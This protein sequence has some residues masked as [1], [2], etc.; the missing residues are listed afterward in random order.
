MKKT[1]G[2]THALI[3]IVLLTLVL[4]PRPFVGYRDLRSAQRFEAAGNE[5]DAAQGYASAA[6]RIPWMPS[7][8]EKAGMKAMQV[9][10]VENAIAFFN[11]AVEHDAIS[12]SGWLSL[13]T[14]YQKQGE[15]SLAVKAW[16]KALPLAQ[17]YSYLAAAQRSM[18]NFA[19]AIEYWRADIAL[20][21]GNATAH[22]TLGLLLAATAP[23]QA[24]PELIQSSKL[25]PA[26]DIPV[27]SLRT[28]LNTAFLSD[29]RAYQFLVSG[30]ALGALGEWDLAA[31]AFRN[32]IAGRSNYADAWA[33]LGEAEQQQGQDGAPDIKQALAFDPESAMIQGLYGMY[34]QRQGKPEAALAA[35]QKAADREPEDPG[36]Q[37]ALGSASEQIGDLVAAYGYYTHAVELTPADA[38]TWRALASFSVTNDVD[39]DGTG[40]PAARKLIDLAP[41]DWQSYDLAGQV[42]FLLEDYA[43]AE[44]YLKKSVQ[45]SPTQAAPALHLGLVYMQTGDRTSAYSYLSL[46]RTLDPDGPYGW[47]AGRLLEQYFP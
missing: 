8:W 33:W 16:E 1:F 5:A 46:A 29:D 4:V 39:V 43:S 40:L 10:D 32:T 37:M 13:G 45:M 25:S 22:Y 15:L 17:A 7:L 27:Q 26:L 6:R 9:G 38:S 42:G 11:Q 20:E 36:W 41:D 30:R 21:P 31:E 23:E 35:F 47:Q 34:L 14:A 44:V 19:A 28:A 2:L 18:G 3:L 24:L 12:E